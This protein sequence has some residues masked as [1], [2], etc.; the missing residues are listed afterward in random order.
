[1]T[2]DYFNLILGVHDQMSPRYWDTR[3]REQLNVR[4]RPGFEEDEGSLREAVPLDRLFARVQKLTKVRNAEI[5]S[6]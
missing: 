1:M 2:L 5:E 4:F 6:E 3:L